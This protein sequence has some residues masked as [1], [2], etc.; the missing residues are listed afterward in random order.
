MR[1][2]KRRFRRTRE[3]G[4]RH[5]WTDKLK[6]L[7]VLYDEKSRSFWR[8]EIAASK[9]NSKKLWR[10]FN[11]VLGDVNTD[12]TTNLTADQFATFFQDKVDSV[13]SSTESTPLYDV[14]C[15]STPILDA[16]IH[17]T[18]DEVNKLIGSAPCKTC[19][20]DPAPTWLV[21]DNSGLLSPFIALLFNKSLVTGCFP[22]GFKNAVVRPL[23]KKPDLDAT[24][25]K[26]YGVKLAVP[27]QVIGKSGSQPVTGLLGQQ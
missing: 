10:T 25:P 11:S 15:R 23:L 13:R 22:T 20:L 3:V 24:Q 4:D 2:A 17:V 19:Q 16:L 18:V 8:S 14:P 5:V 12:E 27:V 6:K 21:K 26:N 9:G 1:A 7:R